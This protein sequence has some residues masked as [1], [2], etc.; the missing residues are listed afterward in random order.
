MIRLRPYLQI[1]DRVVRD[2]LR[3]GAM[4]GAALLVFTC[5]LAQELPAAKPLLS[6][7]RGFDERGGEALYA[8]I[9]AACHQQDAKGAIGA[10]VYPALAENK[11]LASADYSLNALLHGLRGMPPVGQ[12]M[13]DEQVADV[14]N[15]VRT[16]FGNDYGDTVSIEE[17]KAAR[18][19]VESAH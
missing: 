13:S 19:H 14:I 5:A 16:H 8:N 9:C 12:M 18:S 15:Y 10:A 6:M 4:L 2:S 17:V 1:E 3:L 11:K 7:G